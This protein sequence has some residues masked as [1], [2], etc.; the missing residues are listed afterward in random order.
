MK[1]MQ[2]QRGYNADDKGAY[3][4]FVDNHSKGGPQ[5]GKP[6]EDSI[7]FLIKH[8]K[9][10]NGAGDPE[11]HILQGDKEIAVSDQAAQDQKSIVHKGDDDAHQKGMQKKGYFTDNVLAHRHLFKQSGKQRFSPAVCR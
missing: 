11:N 3:G 5:H 8:I 10:A 7:V 6:P 1:D 4:F 2:D 9:D